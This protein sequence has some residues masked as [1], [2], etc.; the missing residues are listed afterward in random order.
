MYKSIVAILICASLA[1]GYVQG[2]TL[3]EHSRTVTVT[4]TISVFAIAGIATAI[5]IRAKRKS[6]RKEQPC[7]SPKKNP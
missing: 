5:T 3:P 6:A 2:Y 1:Q 7:S 4:V